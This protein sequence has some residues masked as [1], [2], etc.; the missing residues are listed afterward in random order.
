MARNLDLLDFLLFKW[1]QSFFFPSAAILFQLGYGL[2]KNVVFGDRFTCSAV[3]VEASDSS[4]W[5]FN[6]GGLSSQWSF[7]TGFTVACIVVDVEVAVAVIV[8]VYYS[9]FKLYRTCT[10][11]W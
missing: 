5:F 3:H 9:I 4:L 10:E 6:I 2:T 1:N 8:V 11:A 7:Q